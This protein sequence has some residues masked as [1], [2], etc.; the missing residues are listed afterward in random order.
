MDDAGNTRTPSA[1]R[2]R[3]QDAEYSYHA[4]D[5]RAGRRR[6][7]ALVAAACL[8]AAKGAPA[9]TA[10]PAAPAVR[11]GQ[12][13]FDFS[14][15]VWHTHIRRVLD[16]FSGTGEFVELNGT[17]TSRPVWGGKAWLEEIDADG[18]K[19]HWQGAS[20][21]LYN[22]A[23]HQWSQSFVNSKSGMFTG[24]M[25]GE[26]RN[27]VGELFASDT[28]KGRAILVRAWWSQIQP[29][30]HRY[31]EFYSAD[32]GVTWALSF[33]AEKTRQEPR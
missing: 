12:H 23:S 32:G 27:G 3:M 26:F 22:P 13:D 14:R 4:P 28:F 15:G 9:D 16:P 25:I 18:P 33:R 11:D 31:E 8:I 21:F 1:P 10:E 17:V 29:G 24:G 30:S 2:P 7:L 19:G 5:A 6:A 20:L